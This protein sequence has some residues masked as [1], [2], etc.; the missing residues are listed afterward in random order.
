MRVFTKV[1]GQLACWQVDDLD[2]LEAIEL[3]RSVV[4][5]ESGSEHKSAILALVKY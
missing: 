5:A 3:V 2:Y 4:Q 1:N